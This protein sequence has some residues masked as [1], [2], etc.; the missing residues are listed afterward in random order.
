MMNV[1]ILLHKYRFLF[2]K[3]RVQATLL[4]GVAG[5]ADQ[6]DEGEGEDRL[7]DLNPPRGD[8]PQDQ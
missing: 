7:P 3:E 5:E 2:P 6:R 1:Y 8:E 4:S